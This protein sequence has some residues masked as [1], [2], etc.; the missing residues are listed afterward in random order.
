MTTNHASL[1]G[2]FRLIDI[3]RRTDERGALCFAENCH[4]PFRVERVFWIFGVPEGKTRGGHAHRTCA[5][6]VF[7]VNGSFDMFVDDGQ[8]RR[9]FHME[10]PDQGIYIGPEVWCELRNF[11]PG[12]ICVVVA[13]Q[14]YDAEGYINEYE[15]FKKQYED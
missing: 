11:A 4:L 9:T 14:E 10:R 7:P 1:P 12:T 15:D 2:T 8:T 6:V 5:E 13:S 3:P